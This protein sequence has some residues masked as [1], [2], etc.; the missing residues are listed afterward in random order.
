[1][2]SERARIWA[3]LIAG[4]NAAEQLPPVRVIPGG[5]KRREGDHAVS[6]VRGD[7]PEHRFLA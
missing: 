3:E 2:W 7:W 5:A 6:V 4:K 1:M